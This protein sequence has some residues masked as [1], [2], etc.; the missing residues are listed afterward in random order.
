M[1]NFPN[2]HLNSISVFTDG[3]ARGNP[4]PSAIGVY[5]VDQNQKILASF[6]RAIG[7]ATNN[8]AEYQAVEAALSWIAENKEILGGYSSINFFVDSQLVYSQL[9]GLFKI[10][11]AKLRELIF[12][13][14]QIETQILLPIHYHHIP[15]EKNQEADRLVNEALD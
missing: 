6:G 14:R 3:G 13:I 11:N 10:K 7:I 2:T 15:R 12:Q 5:I 9:T 4:G 1:K 8:I